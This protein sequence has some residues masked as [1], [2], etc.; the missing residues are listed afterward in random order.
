MT[1]PG[2]DPPLRRFRRSMVMDLE[3]WRE[4]IACPDWQGDRGV[5]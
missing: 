1:F 4:G 2:D 5:T 3:K